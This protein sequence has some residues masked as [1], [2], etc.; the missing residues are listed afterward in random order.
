[1]SKSIDDKCSTHQ[2]N[3]E[4]GHH[5]KT[6]ARIRL[7]LRIVRK[8]V[9]ALIA[10][11]WYVTVDNGEEEEIRNSRSVRDV[12]AKVFLTDEDFIYVSKKPTPEGK[13]YD[14]FVRFIY[15]NGGWDVMNDYSVALE[16]VLKPVSEYAETQDLYA[17]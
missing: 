1:M 6:C 13:P 14:H 3:P 5:C 4:P 17:A 2:R 12:M 16:K 11:G 7:E 15:G 9:S 10:A 8:T